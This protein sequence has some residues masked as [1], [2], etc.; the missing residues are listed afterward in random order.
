M[1]ERRKSVRR[2]MNQD[3]VVWD[4]TTKLVMGRVENVSDEG[5]MLQCDHPLGPGAFFNCRLKWPEFSGPTEEAT[6]HAQSMW[7]RPRTGKDSWEVG[8]HVPDFKPN[9]LAALRSMTRTP[10]TSS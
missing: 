10:I 5:V 1:E 3:L 2:P 7:C 8:F 6:F 9:Q 4:M